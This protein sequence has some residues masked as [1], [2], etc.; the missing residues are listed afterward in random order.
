MD[1]RPPQ[2]ISNTGS[3]IACNCVPGKVCVLESGG[4]RQEQ[5]VQQAPPTSARVDELERRVYTAP[6]V[7]WTDGDWELEDV[8]DGDRVSALQIANQDTAEDVRKTA[9]G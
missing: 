9:W 5:A 3:L 1:T 4:C 8:W 2:P 6:Y 7:A